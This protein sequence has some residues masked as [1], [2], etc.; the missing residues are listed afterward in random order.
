[1]VKIRLVRGGV[2]NKPVFRIIVI[3]SRRKNDGEVIE[4]LGI[5]SKT[6]NDLVVKRDRVDY[7]LKQGAQ[8][9]PTLDKL[10]KNG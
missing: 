1:M 4:N 2:A 5:W 6:K 7:W 10:L 9:S 8:I 3:E